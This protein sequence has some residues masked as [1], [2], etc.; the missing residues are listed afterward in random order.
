MIIKKGT[1]SILFPNT[2]SYLKKYYLIKY[3][4]IKENIPDVKVVIMNR[5]G[6][7]FFSKIKELFS[8]ILWG[9]HG[10]YHH[11]LKTI[12]IY[13]EAFLSSKEALERVSSNPDLACK[14][15]DSNNPAKSILIHEYQHFLQK[16]LSKVPFYSKVDL[17]QQI[18][19]KNIKE[20]ILTKIRSEVK[21]S[22]ILAFFVLGFKP[23]LG[24][25]LGIT[26]VDKLFQRV[27]PKTAYFTTK[28]VAYEFNAKEIESRMAE[29]VYALVL[30]KPPQDMLTHLKQTEKEL[31]ENI[32]I[33]NNGINE[34][35]ELFDRTTN[36]E[37]RNKINK[38]IRSMTELLWK[39]ERRLEL[40][41]TLLIEA[42]RIAKKVS[43]ELEQEW[44]VN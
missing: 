9:T 12:F 20:Q 40:I 8:M 22:R 25:S 30:G 23:A 16:K 1:F 34:Q 2:Y 4:G 18:K 17:P 7:T 29:M 42:E 19:N 35:R 21:F 5:K 14:F 38:I 10:A 24:Y 27:A 41:P 11:S 36:V 32:E 43:K 6:Y 37:E 3:P 28:N 33:L 39:T 31:K 44:E 15:L 13:V 26:L